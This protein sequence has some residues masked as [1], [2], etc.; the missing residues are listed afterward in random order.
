MFFKGGKVTFPNFFPS[1]KCFFPSRNFHFG[2]PKQ[3][4]M[5]SKNDRQK[6]KRPLLIYI[7]SLFHFQFSSSPFTISLLFLS[8]FPFSLPLF[9]LSSSF[10]LFLSLFPPFPFLPKFPPNF[11]RVGDL[12]TKMNLTFLQHRNA[13]TLQFLC[14]RVQCGNAP[15][16]RHSMNGPWAQ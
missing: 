4:S 11:P 6:K 2:T 14:S 8:I 16:L 12:P 1:V 15:R 10:S 5:V 7:P 3:I 13:V 9:S